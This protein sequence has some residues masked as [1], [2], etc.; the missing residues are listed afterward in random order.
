MSSPLDPNFYVLTATQQALLGNRGVRPA[1][2]S[3]ALR[4]LDSLTGVAARRAD[5]TTNFLKFDWD[6]TARHRLSLQ[7]NRVRASSPAGVKV[8][9]VVDR[10]VASIG[11]ANTALDRVVGRWMWLRSSAMSHEVR[12]QFARDL[13]SESAQQPLPQEAAVGPGGSAPEVLIGQQG[14]QFGTPASLGRRAYPDER[15]Y[16]V[17]DHARLAA[18]APSAAAW[19]GVLCDP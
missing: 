4:Y 17:D 12:L 18:W 5:Q 2:T 13:Q 7:Y 1:Q 8:E 3:A 14:F 19:R 6:A 11:N 9:P 16:E 10:G 15:R